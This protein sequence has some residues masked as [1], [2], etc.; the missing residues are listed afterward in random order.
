MEISIF[1]IVNRIN[2]ASNLLFIRIIERKEQLKLTK[3]NFF[4][5]FI[6]FKKKLKKNN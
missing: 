6:F 4:L 5:I 2:R 1:R 3:D